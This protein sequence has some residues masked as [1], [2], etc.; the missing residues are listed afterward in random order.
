MLFVFLKAIPF[1][2]KNVSVHEK[3]GGIVF[4][5]MCDTANCFDLEQQ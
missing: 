5:R 1:L 4:H 3:I 2:R